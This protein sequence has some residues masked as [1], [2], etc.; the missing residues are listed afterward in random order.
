MCGVGFAAQSELGTQA[1]TGPGH[2]FEIG[3]EMKLTQGKISREQAL[4]ISK[5]YVEFVEDFKHIDSILE[6]F[7]KLKRGQRCIAFVRGEGFFEVKVT[8]LKWTFRSQDGYPETRVSNGEYSWRCDGDGY[9]Y[10]IK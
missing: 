5:E 8:S 2:I 4:A 6:T 10:P 9:A 3:L 7:S 1:I